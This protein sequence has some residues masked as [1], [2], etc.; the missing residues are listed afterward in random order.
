MDDV[1]LAV[2]SVNRLLERRGLPELDLETYRRVFRFPVSDYYADV[3]IDLTS[4]DM[5][6]VSDEFHEGYLAGVT[7]CGM[8]KGTLPLLER[9]SVAGIRQYVLSAA[10]EGMLLEWVGMLGIG[11][12][13]DGVYGLPDRLAATKLDRGHDLVATHHLN[14][15]R[16]AFIGDT[17]HDVEVAQALGCRPVLVACGHQDRQRLL[18]TGAQVCGSFQVLLNGSATY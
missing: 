11:R 12:F 1:A 15:T 10:E 6:A 18:A 5:S 8:H 14:V 9:Y 4:D 7:A 3:G 2:R 16:T 13:F 17:D